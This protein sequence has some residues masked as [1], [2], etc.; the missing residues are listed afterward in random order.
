MLGIAVAYCTLMGCA[1]ETAT[2]KTHD[3][4]PATKIEVAKVETPSPDSFFVV[5]LYDPERDAVKDLE[6]TTELASK[7]GKRILIEVGGKW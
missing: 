5:D 6:M 1:S 2:E 3:D 7:T 4:R